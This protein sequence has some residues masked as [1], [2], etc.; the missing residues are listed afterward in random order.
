MCGVASAGVVPVDVGHD[1]VA[2]FVVGSES[3]LVEQLAFE[4]GE[5]R[6]GHGVIETIT[7]RSHR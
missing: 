7:D 6:L 3:V 2:G 5:E 4:G 1:L